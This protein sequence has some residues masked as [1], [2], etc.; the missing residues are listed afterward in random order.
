MQTQ[1]MPA[2]ASL[3][4]DLERIGAIHR[5]LGIP[6]D[7]GTRSGL[8][9]H[10]DAPQL[11]AVE[12][13]VFERPQKMAPHAAHKWQAMRAQAEQQDVVLLLVSAFRSIQY[14]HE[15]IA[16]KLSRGQLIEDILKIN[17]AP[18]YSEHHSGC[19]L[20]LT[21]AD[22][23]SLSTGF[24]TTNA[25]AWLTRHAGEFGFKLSYPRDNSHGIIYEPWHWA[26]LDG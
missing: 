2:P 11:Q 18:G 24:E 9:M 8:C 23:A 16:R 25:F 15:L 1:S 20:D 17:A 6:E 21:T 26:C 7:Y 10:L 3:P 22:C 12:N 13:D 19:A 5:G 14:Q 4:D